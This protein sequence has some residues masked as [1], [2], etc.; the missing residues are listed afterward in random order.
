MGLVAACICMH[1]C[2]ADVLR[3]HPRVLLVGSSMLQRHRQCAVECA[4]PCLTV[5]GPY[6]SPYSSLRLAHSLLL[7][8][9][10][11]L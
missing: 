3:W 2:G 11:S 9:T 8:R 7:T 5:A 1:G 6:G 4:A 10:E